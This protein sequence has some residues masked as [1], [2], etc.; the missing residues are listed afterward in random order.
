[1]SA[2]DYR[3]AIVQAA[4]G[5]LGSLDTRV[6]DYWTDAG[7]VAPF[8]KEWC[9][10]FALWCLHQAGCGLDVHWVIGLG[11]LLVPPRALALVVTPE[12]G[13]VSYKPHPWQHH[14][15]V[16]RV[17]GKTVHTIDGNQGPP[18]FIKRGSHEL[19]DGRFYFDVSRLIPT[20]V[21]P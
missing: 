3:E 14:A 6:A 15:I 21:T 5:Q 16:E 2:S 8:P 12:P 10:A 13:D 9:G 11:F 4:A 20:E 19:G 18:S 7:C 17:E 1:M